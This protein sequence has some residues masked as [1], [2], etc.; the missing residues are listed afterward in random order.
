MRS[1]LL[2][3]AVLFS[4]TFAFAQ[5]DPGTQA[6]QANQQASEELQRVKRYMGPFTISQS[7]TLQV[8]AV[9]PYSFR[10]LVATATY[11]LPPPPA[12]P[13]NT[14]MSSALDQPQENVVPVHFVS[15]RKFLP[16]RRRSA[17]KFL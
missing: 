17:T 8:I 3:L 16:P 5:D 11:T 12:P 15:L 9:A 7:T 14:Q 4:A 2:L 13:A 1:S 6:T 10:S